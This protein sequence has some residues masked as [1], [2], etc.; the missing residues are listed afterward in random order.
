MLIAFSIARAAPVAVAP[1]VPVT[2]AI[3]AVVVAAI[4]EAPTKII[5]HYHLSKLFAI[6]LN[7]INIE[8]AC[9]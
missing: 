3:A 7:I 1:M 9:T 5:Q 8:N 6:Y 4:P 2:V